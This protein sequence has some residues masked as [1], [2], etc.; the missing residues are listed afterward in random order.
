MVAGRNGGR[1]ERWRSNVSYSSGNLP[2]VRPNLRASLPAAFSMLQTLI[3]CV[4]CFA[5]KAVGSDKYK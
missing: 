1:L 4:P 3:F 2:L 5:H